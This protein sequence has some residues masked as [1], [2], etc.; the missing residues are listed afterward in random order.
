MYEEQAYTPATVA[1]VV[2]VLACVSVLV[3]R[4]FE[5]RTTHRA[6]QTQQH[7]EQLCFVPQL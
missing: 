1:A 6:K 7:T 5:F 4:E 3:L 2:F